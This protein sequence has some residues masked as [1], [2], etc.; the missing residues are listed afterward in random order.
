MEFTPRRKTYRVKAG[1][2]IEERIWR[3]NIKEGFIT[4]C[5]V[6]SREELAAAKLSDTQLG[7][8]KTIPHT[9]DK[10]DI[11]TWNGELS[12]TSTQKRKRGADDHQVGKGEQKRARQ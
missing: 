1:E 10:K 9:L 3:I 11:L 7:I 4:A 5:R 2:K 8:W 12:R 6:V